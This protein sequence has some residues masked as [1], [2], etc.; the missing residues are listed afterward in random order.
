[1]RREIIMQTYLSA[2]ANGDKN[3]Y[4][5]DGRAL[6]DTHLRDACTADGCHPNDLGFYRMAQS[7]YRELSQ[8]LK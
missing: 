7:V 2:R 3:V 4:F 8:I 6:F 1:V 5:C